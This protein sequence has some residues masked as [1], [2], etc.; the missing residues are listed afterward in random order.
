M[1]ITAIAASDLSDFSVKRALNLL[2]RGTLPAVLRSSLSK[3]SIV[4]F[5]AAIARL[6]EVAETESAEQMKKQSRKEIPTFDYTFLFR[7]GPTSLSIYRDIGM[8]VTGQIGVRGNEPCGPYFPFRRCK[9]P[10]SP[11]SH[12]VPHVYVKVKQAPSPE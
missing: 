8:R 5:A 6:T 7:K 12:P 2:C 10:L 1:A 9:S 11:L 4:S 3:A